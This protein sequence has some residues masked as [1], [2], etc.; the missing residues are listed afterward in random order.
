MDKLRT[1]KSLPQRKSDPLRVLPI[2][3]SVKSGISLRNLPD[4]GLVRDKTPLT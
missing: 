4:T 3:K 2:C 1:V